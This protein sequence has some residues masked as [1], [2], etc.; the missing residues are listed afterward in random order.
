M[1]HA[2]HTCTCD[3]QRTMSNFLRFDEALAVAQSLGL[4]NKAEWRVWCKEGMRRGNVP[5]YPERVY[6]GGGW[7][8]WGHWLGTGNTRNTRNTT[9]F[10]PFG[11]A[12]AAARS[13]GLASTSEWQQWSKAG[14]RPP[15]VPTPPTRT[16][17]GRG[18]ATGW[19]PATRPTRRRSSC[20]LQTRWPWRSPSGWPARPSERCGARKAGGRPTCPPA[21]APGLQGRRVAGVGPLAGHGHSRQPNKAVP[22]VW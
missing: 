21:H 9:P 2:F 6:N 16:T 5:A 7:Q 13:L 12:L 4:A 19:A 15:N 18:G 14:R 1:R 11:E 20:R 3:T 10:L 8:G 22:A 17:G